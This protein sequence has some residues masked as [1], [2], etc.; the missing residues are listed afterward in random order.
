MI[1]Y[2]HS[3]LRLKADNGFAKGKSQNGNDVFIITRDDLELDSVRHL[4]TWLYIV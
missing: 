1:F 3:E 2:P 4:N